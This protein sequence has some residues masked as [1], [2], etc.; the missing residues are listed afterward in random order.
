MLLPNG[1]LKTSSVARALNKIVTNNGPPIIKVVAYLVQKYYLNHIC[2]SSYNK[3]TKGIAERPHFDVRQ[4]F[5]KAVNGDQSKWSTAAYTV[6]WS[7]HVTVYQCMGCSLYY[8]A[9]STHPLFPA[10]ILEATYL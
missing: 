2:I 6:F 5:F 10:N 1:Y 3:H 9:T 4:A 7:E 8:A